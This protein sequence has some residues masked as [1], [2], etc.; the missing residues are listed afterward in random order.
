MEEYRYYLKQLGIQDSTIDSYARILERFLIENPENRS[1]AYKD[2]V[3]YMSQIKRQ[4]SESAYPNK[5]L[6]AIKKYY[7][8][9]V[10]KGVR[11]DHP[12]QNLNIKNKRQNKYLNKSLTEE[13]LELLLI[14]DERYKI[15]EIKN[16][17]IIS[18]LIYQGLT[19]NEVV[20]LKV[21]DIDLDEGEVYI[22]PSPKQMSR[23]L[24]LKP[25]QYRLADR[26]IN[27]DRKTLQ[28]QQEIIHK[29][30]FLT[31]TG[32]PIQYDDVKTLISQQRILVQRDKL[33]ATIIRQSVIS[34]W[35]N[36]KKNPLEQ[37]QLLSGHKW[38][39]TTEKYLQDNRVGKRKL[40]NRYFPY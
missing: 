18:L 7:S 19:V 8:Y 4:Y 36:E 6:A 15:Q 1:Y 12:C 24:Q 5:V 30:L 14:R 11:N 23:R 31:K 28:S 32:N 9:L 37:V 17:F 38:I 33:T 20:S 2:I 34:N 40:I 25:K 16:K 22:R 21:Q 26:Y 35:L 3:D 39:S 29:S 27:D 10:E 13:E